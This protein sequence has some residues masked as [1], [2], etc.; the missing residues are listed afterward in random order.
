MKWTWK[1]ENGPSEA[2]IAGCSQSKVDPHF[3]QGL[4]LAALAAHDLYAEVQRMQGELF[5]ANEDR[6]AQYHEIAR[7][8]AAAG[9]KSGRSARRQN[10]DRAGR[11]K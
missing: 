11:S 7:L 6:L 8:K 3:F 9:P 1:P 10:V 4:C 5:A 2:A